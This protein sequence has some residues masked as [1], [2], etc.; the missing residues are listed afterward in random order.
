MWPALARAP[1]P[2]FRYAGALQRRCGLLRDIPLWAL[3]NRSS[4]VAPPPPHG[5][6]KGFRAKTPAVATSGIGRAAPSA[7][8][9][10]DP[11]H[12]C[13]AGPA[14]I[15]S[16]EPSPFFP[17]AAPHV[18]AGDTTRPTIADIRR[19][20]GHPPQADPPPRVPLGRAWQTCGRH[21]A[22]MRWESQSDGASVGYLVGAR[23][24][25]T[26]RAHRRDVQIDATEVHSRSG[27][28]A[29]GDDLAVRR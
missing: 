7:S 11:Q 14:S 24:P 22:N 8:R 17:S 19:L 10:P 20:L 13:R 3:P 12:H 18:C 6:A 2:T 28:P 27:R 25:A 21:A 4:H 29:A 15:S 26:S 1:T 23:A 9:P 5:S 16:S